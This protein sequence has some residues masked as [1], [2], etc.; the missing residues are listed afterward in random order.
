MFHAVIAVLAQCALAFPTD[1]WWLAAAAPSSFFAAR[2][3]TQAEYR[4]IEAWG[5]GKR[6]NL[7]AWGAVDPRVW[8]RKSLLDLALP[9]AAT[10]LLALAMTSGAP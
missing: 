4:W 3:L 7:P 6:T 5:Q 10:A 2:E 9:V 8:D 1:Q